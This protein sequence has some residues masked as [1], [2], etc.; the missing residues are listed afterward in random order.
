MCVKGRGGVVKPADLASRPDFVLGP[1]SISPARRRVEGPD[2]HTQVEP[3]IM[4]VFLLLL[5]ADGQVVTRD[6]LFD[7]GWGGAMVGDDSLNRAINRVRRIDADVGPGVFEIETV[8]RTGYRLTG[9]F[10]SKR[11]VVI[12]ARTNPVLPRRAVL[13][14]G[15]AAVAGVASFGIW[16]RDT[17]QEK[18]FDMLL[19]QGNKAL[20]YADPSADADQFFKR[21]L[22]LRPRDPRALGLYA[23]A[24]SLRADGPD[25]KFRGRALEEADA[26]ARAALTIDPS[27]ADALLAQIVNQQSALDLFETEDRLRKIL[28]TS[29]RNIN[30]MRKLWDM[31]QCVGRSREA[32]AL[33]DRALAVDPFGA[34]CHYPKAQLLWI[35][36]KTAE[37][38][39][40]VDNA[41]RY[42][43]DNRF[44]RFARFTILAFTGRARAALAML[45]KDA[46]T[47]QVFSPESVELWRPT[48]MALD[49]GSAA[50]IDAARTVNLD[51][52][53]AN[54]TLCRQAA[55]SLSALGD[56]DG[57]FKVANALFAV[58]GGQAPRPQQPSSS[59]AWRFAP[60]MFIPPT[61]PM[62]ADPRFDTLCE[63][64]GL[65]DYWAKR[66]VTPDY[67][68]GAA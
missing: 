49:D 14:G 28:A 3:L 21:A 9:D 41:L 63:V 4:H 46:T 55:I 2:G 30:V 32:L 22:T 66:Q 62:R 60:W 11:A 43:P 26:S 48:L 33:V 45:E 37:A 50:Q 42:W 6:A 13:A 20:N 59:A 61:A 27:Q 12:G 35:T 24:V 15:L 44:V 18:E 10:R 57:A 34:G 8:P 38:D 53:M 52:A 54:L 17:R 39:R 64:I 40:V 29:P 31:L 7:A 1:L 19:A 58:P 16:T 25:I 36:G 67:R 47:P 65:T 68:L 5:D 23:Y 56:V 51:R